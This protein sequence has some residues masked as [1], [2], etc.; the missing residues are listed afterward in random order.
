VHFPAKVIDD[1][2]DPRERE[3]RQGWKLHVTATP[4]NA[5]DTLTRIIPVLVRRNTPFKLLARE[6]PGKSPCHEVLTILA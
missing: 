5:F 2:A 3:L 1:Y 6:R 4:L